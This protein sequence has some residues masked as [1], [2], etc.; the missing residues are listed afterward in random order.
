MVA[1]GMGLKCLRDGMDSANLVSMF[2]VEGNPKGDWNFFSQ[3]F[4]NHITAATSLPTKALS[5]KFAT[6]TSFIQEVGLSDW[7]THN[8]KGEAVESAEFPFQLRFAPT[9]EAK[10]LF[11]SE[12]ENENYMAYVDQLT[13]VPD[14]MVI[15][16]VYGLDKPTE[17]GGTE[18][19]VGHLRVNGGFEKSKFQ[20]ENLFIRHQ[21]MDDDLKIHPEWKPYTASWKCFSKCPYKEALETLSL[22]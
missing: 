16:D 21:L 8:E 11:P 3:D 17:L 18:S 20:D 10:A 4:R 14:Q 15:Y 1:P 13:T 19:L 5:A 6:E 22:Y 2:S 12:L 7:A 9:A